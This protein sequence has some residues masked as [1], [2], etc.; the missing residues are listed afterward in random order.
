MPQGEQA[1]DDHASIALKILYTL[2]GTD[3]QKY[4]VKPSIPV[5][6]RLFRDL[7]LGVVDIQVCLDAIRKVSPD[8]SLICDT[9]CDEYAVY[10]ADYAEEGLPLQSH[11]KV[12]QQD[13]TEATGKL[14]I[15]KLNREQLELLV[16]LLPIRKPQDRINDFCQKLKSESFN[17]TSA[18]DLGLSQSHRN[19][20]SFPLP[21]ASFMNSS[22]LPP[23]P[24]QV[25]IP[26]SLASGPNMRSEAALSSSSP[27]R[28]KPTKINPAMLGSY[29][30][31]SDSSESLSNVGI[32]RAAPENSSGKKRKA[33]SPKAE[34]EAQCGNCGVATASTWRRA[35]C[36]DGKG[37]LLCNACGLY[38]RAKKVMRPRFLWDKMRSRSD[39]ESMLSNTVE[40][41]ILAQSELI[42]SSNVAQQSMVSMHTNDV[43]SLQA[44]IIR[45]ENA[46]TPQDAPQML[47]SRD[48][49]NS[50]FT[51]DAAELSDR[52][53]D[54][55]SQLNN[56]QHTSKQGE[57]ESKTV[58][59]AEIGQVPSTPER[60][61]N[62]TP[63]EPDTIQ[64]WLGLTTPDQRMGF[65][66]PGSGSARKWLDHALN[67]S[68]FDEV[69]NSPTPRKTRSVLPD[70]AIFTS[71]PPCSS[72]LL[73]EVSSSL[74]NGS[75]GRPQTLNFLRETDS[76][77]EPLLRPLL[78]AEKLPNGAHTE[79]V[80]S[81]THNVSIKKCP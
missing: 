7:Q 43:D 12:S 69:W 77:T 22:M 70:L 9:H 71:S 24:P 15:S 32:K 23:L 6:A 1:N 34:G 42:S 59:S 28:A 62:L 51:S 44:S 19:L 20:L 5:K 21:P 53:I 40:T 65:L 48:T 75:P 31:V 68:N 2:H 10:S 54:N 27:V 55:P 36:P 17:E 56:G 33:L 46:P 35:R 29:Q 74:A 3:S 79:G 64:K 13:M 41:Q 8:F 52:L 58:S 61:T 81:S 78:E 39:Q 76:E 37:E 73:S 72:N 30:D 50:Y 38:Y 18:N 14:C 25:Q 66:I 60:K 57:E 67:P 45:L 47:W 80:K 26:S 63:V 4:I 11:G 16:H 49:T